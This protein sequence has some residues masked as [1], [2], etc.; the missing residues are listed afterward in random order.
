MEFIPTGL[1][2]LMLIKP[3]VYSDPR[4]YFFEKFREDLFREAGLNERFVQDNQSRSEKGVIR[5]LHYQLAP[6]AQAK[7]LHVIVG[8]IWDVAV[9]LRRDS[10]TFGQWHGELLSGENQLQMYIPR[11]FAHGFAVLSE[12]AI[13]EYK[14]DQVYHPGSERGIIY[15]DPDLGIDWKVPQTEALVSMKD[16]VLPTFREAEMNFLA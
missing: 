7:L 13:V 10:A 16:R 6:Y 3:R 14:C 4:G 11:G 5:G 12:E 9:D 1:A 8:E 2:G 15:N